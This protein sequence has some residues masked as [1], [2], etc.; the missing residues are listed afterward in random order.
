MNLKKITVR[1]LHGIFSHDVNFFS[2]YT[3]IHGINGTG[4][5]SLLNALK[6]ILLPDLSWL[7]FNKYD[8]IEVSIEQNDSLLSFRAK[9]SASSLTLY[10]KTSG[11]IA[12]KEIFDLSRLNFVENNYNRTLA[13]SDRRRETIDSLV[14]SIF[15]E[16]KIIKE[17]QSLPNPAFLG[18]DRTAA[19]SED[20][21]SIYDQRRFFK[22]HHSENS[23]TNEGLRQALVLVRRAADKYN[24]KKRK[25]ED[26]LRKDITFLLFSDLDNFNTLEIPTASDI[27]KYEKMSREITS[28]L[29]R[30]GYE[31]KEIASKI[32]P[33]FTDLLSTSK[34]LLNF[35]DIN[36]I[37][38][39]KG[40]RDESFRAAV[41]WL[42]KSP[43][44][45]L[46][47]K[48][49]SLIEDFNKTDRNIRSEISKYEEIINNFFIDS[50]KQVSILDSGSVRISQSGSHFDLSN[51]SS[52][53]KHIFMLLSH[54]VFNPLLARANVL[55]IDEPEVSLHV[56]WQEIFVD[57]VLEANPN[58]QLVMATHSPS[59]VL[60]KTD[61]MV[62]L[63]VS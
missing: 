13:D 19:L 31:H 60:D 25:H 41:N 9:K 27:R 23:S 48:Y 55:V 53:E 62:E 1:N 61:R 57:S 3:F 7:T 40:S 18:L 22:S 44:I 28:T 15:S 33:L 8:S 58:T 47:E 4:K 20:F 14:I 32:S 29:S 49:F 38:N 12:T 52:G 6:A 54:L 26:D 30:L 50:G 17:I 39:T 5:T 63:D 43:V 24:S 36:E 56:R 2:D 51:M 59:I 34:K 16:S 45:N 42:N 46:L 11:K 35:R 37:L 10:K 21:D